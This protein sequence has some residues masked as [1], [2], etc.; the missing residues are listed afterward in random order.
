MFMKLSKIYK[1]VKVVFFYLSVCTSNHSPTQKMMHT[2]TKRYKYFQTLFN[3]LFQF[4]F[5][6]FFK[7]HKYE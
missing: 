3:S 1:V 5:F 7:E 4:L 6:F 2:V